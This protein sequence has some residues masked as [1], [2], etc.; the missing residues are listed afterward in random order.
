MRARHIAQTWERYNTKLARLD[1]VPSGY[2]TTHALYRMLLYFRQLANKLQARHGP[3]A[4]M[5]AQAEPQPK[6]QNHKVQPRRLLS[7]VLFANDYPAA[8]NVTHER[9]LRRAE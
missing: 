8:E 7:R 4:S 2:G 1:A 9:Q 3:A 6:D 5:H